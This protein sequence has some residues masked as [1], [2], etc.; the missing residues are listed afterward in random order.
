MKDFYDVFT[1][2]NANAA[3]AASL[4]HFEEIRIRDLKRYLAD[5]LISVRI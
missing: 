5:A 3:L 2:A 4:F 1:N